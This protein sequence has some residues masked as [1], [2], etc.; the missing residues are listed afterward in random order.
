MGQLENYISRIPLTSGLKAKGNNDFP[1]MEAHSIVVEEDGTRLDTKLG[2]LANT[3][4]LNALA[5]RVKNIEDNGVTGGGGSGGGLT[6]DEV[7]ELIQKEL[8][9][10]PMDITSFSN[11]PSVLELGSTTSTITLSWSTNK[12]PTDL[13]LDGVTVN[14]SDTRKSVS[15]NYASNKTWTLYAKDEREAEDSMQTTLYVVHPF[16]CGGS[17]SDTITNVNGLSKFVARNISGTYEITLSNDGYIYFVCFQSESISRITN[18][19]N[20]FGISYEQTGTIQR[21]I[22]GTYYTYKVY[23]SVKLVEGTYKLKVE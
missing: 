23:R 21:Y 10:E 16:Y 17:G 14:I 3:S 9:Y 2:S 6:E 8:S 11:S 1:L 5:A 13:K 22:N 4:D 12:T 20:G 19:E 7:K 15:G 18:A